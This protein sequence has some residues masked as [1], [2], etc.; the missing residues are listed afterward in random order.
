MYLNSK[1]EYIIE[2]HYRYGSKV[3]DFLHIPIPNCDKEDGKQCTLD[4]FLL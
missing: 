3:D 4:E 1:N 2:L